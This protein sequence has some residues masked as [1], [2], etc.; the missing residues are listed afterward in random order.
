MMRPLS[1]TVSLCGNVFLHLH[2]DESVE[3]KQPLTEDTSRFILSTGI[4]TRVPN[5]TRLLSASRH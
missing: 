2:G 1:V 3:P 4:P 5:A